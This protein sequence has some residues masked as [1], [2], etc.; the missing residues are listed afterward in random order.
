LPINLQNVVNASVDIFGVFT[1]SKH[2]DLLFV[3]DG[4]HQD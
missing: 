1:A 4:L 2:S 3:M